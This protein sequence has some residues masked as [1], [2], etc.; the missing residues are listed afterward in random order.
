M[1][2]ALLLGSIGT[3]VDSSELQRRAFNEAFHIHSL[4]WN[5]EREE[6]CKLLQISGGSK[7]IQQYA[8]DRGE[9]VDAS[10]IHQTKSEIFH[11]LMQRPEVKLRTGVAQTVDEIKKAG[12]LLGLVTTTSQ[13]NVDQ[14]LDVVE[15]QLSRSAFDVIIT[16][17]DVV[18]GK[19]SSECYELALV[20][21]GVQ[22]SDA[23]AVEDNIDG[24]RSAKA[25]GIVCIAFPNANTVFHEFAGAQAVTQEL[26]SSLILG[27]D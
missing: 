1:T 10:A 23:R 6:Y 15:D 14:M 9:A 21:L 8:Q 3:I 19:P 13:E 18:D 17:N 26:N 22:A 11:Q 2:S 12:W 27:S 20:K 4:S 24:L 7:R 5:W 16:S 25:A